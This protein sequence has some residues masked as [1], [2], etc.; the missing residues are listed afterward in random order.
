MEKKPKKLKLI[1]IVIYTN[2]TSKKYYN[3]NLKFKLKN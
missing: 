2:I 3:K 1:K